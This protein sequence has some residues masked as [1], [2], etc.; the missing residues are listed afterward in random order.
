MI[1]PLVSYILAIE[2]SDA[3][4]N[5]LFYPQERHLTNQIHMEND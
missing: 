2:G 3:Q 5:T 1:D 4:E